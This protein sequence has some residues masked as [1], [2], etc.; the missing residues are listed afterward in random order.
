MTKS[1][2]AY[3]DFLKSNAGI[4][5]VTEDSRY[6]KD[7]KSSI[8][9]SSFCFAYHKSGW[10]YEFCC[11]NKID[12]NEIFSDGTFYIYRKSS[13]SFNSSYF[14]VYKSSY[15]NLR[16]EHVEFSDFKNRSFFMGGPI[17]LF[18]SKTDVE[19]YLKQ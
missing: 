5:V 7:L 12:E 18:Y 6:Y 19:N 4:T 11:S 9:S 10:V 1:V 2:D 17:K 16:H 14:D 3:V 8:D 15:Y 13:N